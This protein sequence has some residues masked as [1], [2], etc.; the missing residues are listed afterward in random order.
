[1][2]IIVDHCDESFRKA[3][4]AIEAVLFVPLSDLPAKF[5]QKRRQGLEEDEE[6]TKIDVLRKQAGI[7]CGR[8]AATESVICELN[9]EKL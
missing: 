5:Q 4:P 2:L 3:E 9:H 7:L 8:T 1:M 6:E